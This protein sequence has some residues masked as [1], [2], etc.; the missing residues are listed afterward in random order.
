MSG[1]RFQFDDNGDTFCV[2]LVASVTVILLPLTYYFW[3][4]CEAKGMTSFS[5]I[6]VERI[7]RIPQKTLPMQALSIE[8]KCSAFI[9]FQEMDQALLN[10]IHISFT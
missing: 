8:K 3:P 5:I 10:V 9:F 6:T 4:E 2:F 7:Q 1:D